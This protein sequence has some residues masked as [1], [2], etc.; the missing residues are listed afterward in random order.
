MLSGDAGG[1]A[2]AAAVLR[3]AGRAS[4]PDRFR[5]WWLGHRQQGPLGWLR[6]QPNPQRRGCRRQLDRQ[7]QFLCKGLLRAKAGQGG[8]NRCSGFERPPLG[9]VG[10]IF[11][12]DAFA[13]ATNT[14]LTTPAKTPEQSRN[15]P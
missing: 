7:Q 3:P 2:V 10:Q 8:G 12:I 9:A 11:L 14:G 5:R 6:Q 15:T 1:Q 4:A 13:T